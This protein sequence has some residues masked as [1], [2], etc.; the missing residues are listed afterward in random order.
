LRI[1]KNNKK[2]SNAEANPEAGQRRENSSVNYG[3]G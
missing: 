1:A 3:K 2:N